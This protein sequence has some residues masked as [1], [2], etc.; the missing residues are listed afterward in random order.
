MK[1]TLKV[2]HQDLYLSGIFSFNRRWFALEGTDSWQALFFTM[3]HCS[4]TE[5]II[6][7]ILFIKELNIVLLQWSWEELKIQTLA[8]L[9]HGK[10]FGVFPLLASSTAHS[11]AEWAALYSGSLSVAGTT[12][13]GGQ[14]CKAKARGDAVVAQPGHVVK[15]PPP[16]V[17]EC[18]LSISPKGGLCTGGLVLVATTIRMVALVLK[19]KFAFSS[20][21]KFSS[22]TV[23]WHPDSVNRGFL[24]EPW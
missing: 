19:R 6:Y 13:P 12:A 24:C 20:Q 17:H 1:W 5:G 10:H 14:H 2:K 3:K 7:F 16:G 23:S 22:R 15:S 21:R 8:A 18:L 11:L 4:T 9:P